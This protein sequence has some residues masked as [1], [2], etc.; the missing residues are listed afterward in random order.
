MVEVPVRA[1]VDEE[2][3]GDVDA[4]H[5]L[6]RTPR[7][8]E[9]ELP[10][11]RLDRRFDR[12]VADVANPGL[13]KIELVG[14]D[15]H[16]FARLVADAEE[17]RC[18]LRVRGGGEFVGHDA[19]I[20][21][22]DALSRRGNPFQFEEGILSKPDPAHQVVHVRPFS[23]MDAGKSS[24]AA[25]ICQFCK[26]TVRTENVKWR[27]PRLRWRGGRSGRRRRCR[28]GRGRAGRN[29][30]RATQSRPPSMT[31]LV[32]VTKAPFSEASVSS[33]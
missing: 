32:P 26:R 31:W 17:E 11:R 28:A 4:Q 6:L 30:Q 1:F 27:R 25:S 2:A 24:T 23:Q 10:D 29:G 18:A 22:G 14:G 13:D 3:S 16:D 8:R 19:G 15:A 20:G 21:F 12:I 5:A 33:G 7:I 9:R